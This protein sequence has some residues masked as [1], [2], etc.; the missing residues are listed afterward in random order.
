[1]SKNW[2]LL[3]SAAA[4]WLV[5]ACSSTAPEMSGAEDLGAASGDS[6]SAQQ[7]LAKAP[8]ASY[9][10][11]RPDLRRCAFPRCGGY[12]VKAVN[13][14]LTRCVDGTSQAEC[15]VADLDLSA[16]ALDADSEQVVRG[17][18]TEFLL[19]GAIGPKDFVSLGTFGTLRVLDAYHGHPGVTPSGSFFQANE[20]GIVCITFPCPSFKAQLLNSSTAPA[21][22]AQID[23]S[24]VS[25]DPSDGFAQLHEPE[26]LLLAASRKTVTG[27]A[28]QGFALIGSEYYLPFK[29]K[30][31]AACGSR[32]LSECAA[33]EYCDFPPGA[34][35]G[36]ADAPG[37]CASKPQICTKE[38][39]P[40]CGCDGVTYSNACQ[41][42]ASGVSVEFDG[43]CAPEPKVCG[44]IVGLSCDEG[45]YCDFG[46]GQC[47]TADA[48]GECRP[49]PQVCLEIFDPV[50][51]CDGK[52]YSNSCFAQMVGAQID[53]AGSCK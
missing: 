53:H 32:G 37:V 49:F 21:S 33:G 52:T 25:S 46:V 1:M 13:Q 7:A 11:L 30:G 43:P 15:Y 45:E 29:G 3:F 34:N 26:G 27:P 8:V 19:R 2:N 16:L 44:T 38:F 42:A 5:A 17:S 9:F 47:L 39:K 51:G 28:G 22:V 18:S 10:T 14:K 35:C 4:C 36:R 41:A 20:T 24:G 12:F 50:C 6:D 48:G 23:L 40:V 31:P